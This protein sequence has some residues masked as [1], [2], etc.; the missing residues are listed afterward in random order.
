M[1]ADC[2]HGLLLPVWCDC[3]CSWF[4]R[5]PCC[6][7]AALWLR[8][9]L[10]SFLFVQR[11]SLWSASR[12]F[13]PRAARAMPSRQS[14][15]SAH[16]SSTTFSCFHYR[17]IA[18]ALFHAAA[19]LASFLRR[20]ASVLILHARQRAVSPVHLLR[21]LSSRSREECAI[22][23]HAL[24]HGILPFSSWPTPLPSFFRFACCRVCWGG[25]QATE[26]ACSGRTRAALRRR[27]SEKKNLKRPRVSPTV[28]RTPALSWLRRCGRARVGVRTCEMGA[29]MCDG[30]T[31][32][33]V[34]RLS[35]C[36]RAD[37]LAPL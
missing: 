12:T 29:T 27:W 28:T 34:G 10:L 1:A 18:P 21:L 25:R 16:S 4:F 6:D 9:Y 20:P 5:C 2:R 15:S 17:R 33:W 24:E 31:M 11:A 13:S 19:L 22:G 32:R 3:I 7:V 14:K 35:E 37:R 26:H 23:C 36:S 30:R 8:L